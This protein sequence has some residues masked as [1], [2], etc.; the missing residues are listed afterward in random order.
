MITS[1]VIAIC[2]DCQRTIYKPTDY[3]IGT[4]EIVVETEYL[5]HG[6]WDTVKPKRIRRPITSRKKH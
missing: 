1:T 4:G 2:L 6:R 5:E 3:M